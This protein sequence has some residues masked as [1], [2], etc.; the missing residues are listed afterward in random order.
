MNGRLFFLIFKII[1]YAFGS[2][3]FVNDVVGVIPLFMGCKEDVSY[4]LFYE[5]LFSR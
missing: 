4:F 5:I 2:S 3:L 1:W